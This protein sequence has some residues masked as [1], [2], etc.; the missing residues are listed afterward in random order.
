MFPAALLYRTATPQEA[1]LVSHY[2][3]VVKGWLDMLPYARALS[4]PAVKQRHIALLLQWI[5]VGGLQ[6]GEG[7]GGQV[8]VPGLSVV[9]SIYVLI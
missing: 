8:P 7:R 9:C 6:A 1:G 2:A 3:L 5:K 4:Q